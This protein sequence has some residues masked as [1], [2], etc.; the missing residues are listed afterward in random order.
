MARERSTIFRSRT[1]S[2]HV[3]RSPI[4]PI[5]NARPSSRM[6][7]TAMNRST[8]RYGASIPMTPPLAR[9]V[10]HIRSGLRRYPLPQTVRVTR[11]VDAWALGVDAS[12]APSI[13]SVI[14]EYFTE[15]GFLSTSGLQFPPRSARHRNPVILELLVPQGTPAL[16]L[17]ELAEVRDER[18]I[19]IIDVRTYLVANATFDE[20]RRM[21]RIEAIVVQE[22]Q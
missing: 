5:T 2:W 13:A 6:R 15:L 14:G 20:R 19:L 12:D 7:S 21:W 17:G 8:P 11:E 16:R 1:K 10:A 3:R 9:R 4:S 22:E 18:E